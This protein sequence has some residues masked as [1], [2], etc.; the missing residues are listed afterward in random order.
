MKDVQD[1]HYVQVLDLHSTSKSFHRN[2]KEV[3]IKYK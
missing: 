1:V 3:E 2:E